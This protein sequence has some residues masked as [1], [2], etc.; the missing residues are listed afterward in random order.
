[1]GVG[2]SIICVEHL[3]KQTNRKRHQPYVSLI[4]LARSCLSSASLFT[5]SILSLAF[6]NSEQL[7]CREGIALVLSAMSP[8]NCPLPTHFGGTGPL[9]QWLQD[10]MLGILL[11]S[12]LFW[13]VVVKNMLYVDKKPEK[14][15]LPQTHGN[16]YS[17]RVFIRQST[18]LM[19][20][21]TPLVRVR[22]RVRT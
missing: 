11:G 15:Q 14:R 10:E 8:V 6:C 19:R 2:C 21:Y 1:M 22:F 13:D 12:V 17:V 3:V 16:T 18:P 20:V 5:F 7:H 9:N 4:F